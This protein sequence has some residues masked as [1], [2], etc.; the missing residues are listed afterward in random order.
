MADRVPMPRHQVMESLDSW[1]RFIELHDTVRDWMKK[2]T[3]LAQQQ[4]TLNTLP[5]A[6][7][8][9]NEYKVWALAS[10]G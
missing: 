7:D 10:W 6:R 9:L 3:P 2:Q 4:R 8:A 1:S 5:E